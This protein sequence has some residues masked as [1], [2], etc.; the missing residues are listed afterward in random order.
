MTR[1]ILILFRYIDATFWLVRRPFTQL[2]TV[3]GFVRR[4]SSIKHLPLVFIV[5]SGK[6]KEDYV[7]VLRALYDDVL[8]EV[9]ISEVFE[10]DQNENKTSIAS[11]F[12][13]VL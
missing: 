4:G 11:D 1:F 3:N 6:R 5:M 10:T 7:A 9:R 2:L 8:T 13:F 12:L